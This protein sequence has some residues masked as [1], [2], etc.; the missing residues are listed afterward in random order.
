[1]TQLV[2]NSAPN[3]TLFIYSGTKYPDLSRNV[4]ITSIEVE[5]CGMIKS[6]DIPSSTGPHGLNQMLDQVKD[7][8]ECFDLECDLS[9]EKR[10]DST[11]HMARIGFQFPK[12]K[13]LKDFKNNA[14]DCFSCGDH[15]Q[16]ICT[17]RMPALEIL[18]ISKQDGT[19]DDLV[20]KIVQKQDL[21]GGVKYL[22]VT[23]VQNPESITGLKAA[24]PNLES[25]SIL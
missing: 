18:E 21:F 3:L 12:M 24:F 20:R 5:F 23:D 13:N 25:L 16:D 14:L 2:L 7:H 10:V 15:L 17:A 1:M 22:R 8:L 11:P 9:L 19:V 6:Y 4:A